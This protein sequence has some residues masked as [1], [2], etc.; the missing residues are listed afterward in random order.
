MAFI[1]SLRR[2]DPLGADPRFAEEQDDPRFGTSF[3]D[4]PADEGVA[5]DFSAEQ[6]EEIEVLIAKASTGRLP[7]SRA[8]KPWEPNKL[9]ARHVQMVMMKAAGLRHGVIA[10]ILGVTEANVSVAVN[11][12]DAQTILNRVLSYAAEQATDINA[13][14][15]AH[16]PEMLDIL[17]ETTRS[18][19]RT[20]PALASKNAFELLKMGGYGAVERKEIAHKVE[21]PAAQA[22]LLAQAIDE[23]RDITPLSRISIGP[24]VVGSQANPSP[25]PAVAATPPRSDSRDPGQ[26]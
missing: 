21:V 11:H 26:G 6:R 3:E 13:R 25:S 19:R 10:E 15:K 2:T 1:G 24:E 8:L 12:P 17:I 4:D 16:A 18:S 7:R 20:A 23:S 9:N 14:I 5:L 22:S